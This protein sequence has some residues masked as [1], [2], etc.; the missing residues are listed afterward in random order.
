MAEEVWSFVRKQVM[1]G[2]QAYIVYPVIE[3]SKDDQPEL[4]FSHDDAEA[5]ADAALGPAS[6][7][8]KARPGAPK[9][10]RKKKQRSYSQG[11]PGGESGGKIR[12]EIR[13]GD[14]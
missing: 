1:K 12:A 10:V 2:R 5:G 9:S 7:V 14:A 8:S 4:D 11:C 6:Q 13:R 3:G